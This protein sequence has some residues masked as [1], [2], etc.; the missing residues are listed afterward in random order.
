[1]R[2]LF[3]CVGKIRLTKAVKEVLNPVFTLQIVHNVFNS[4]DLAICEMLS[5]LAFDCL[6]FV[7]VFFSF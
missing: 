3:P 5:T 4:P 7:F 6:V 1:M 2:L